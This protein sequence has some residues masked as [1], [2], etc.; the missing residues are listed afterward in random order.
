MKI[1]NCKECE[2]YEEEINS[3][4]EIK[5][6]INGINV[7]PINKTKY[8]VS[9][10]M[11][12]ISK[13]FFIE[14]EMFRMKMQKRLIE[15]QDKYGDSWKITSLEELRDKITRMYGKFLDKKNTKEEG[16][17]L[18]DFANQCMLLYERKRKKG[19]INY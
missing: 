13:L 7:C 10:Y 12:N 8:H 2:F 14:T 3:C 15:K 17:V 5:E 6:N 16:T 9:C 4:S 19:D 11:E 1:E 18:L